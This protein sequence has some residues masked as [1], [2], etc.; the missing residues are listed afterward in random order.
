MS[1]FRETRGLARDFKERESSGRS[2]RRRMNWRATK[3]IDWLRYPVRRCLSMH[4]CR[5]CR[6]DIILGQEYYDGGHDRR[7]HILCAAQEEAGRRAAE[8]ED[9]E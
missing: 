8:S 3:P 2:S 7:A 1:A 4:L 9:V 5:V 6:H